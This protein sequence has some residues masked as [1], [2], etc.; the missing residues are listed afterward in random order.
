MVLDKLDYC[1]SPQIRAHETAQKRTYTH[2]ELTCFTTLPL[3]RQI[4]VLDK[5]DYC[6]SLHNIG[7]ALAG[8][9]CKVS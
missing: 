1:A 4:V 8:G 3:T 5:L 7:P 6:A 2:K 9:N